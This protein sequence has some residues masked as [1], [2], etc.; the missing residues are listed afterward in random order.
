MDVAVSLS[1][2]YQTVVSLSP[3]GIYTK[4]EYGS[5]EQVDD[6]SGKFNLVAMSDDG[7][8]Q[9]ACNTLQKIFG[10]IKSGTADTDSPPTPEPTPEPTPQ[11]SPT[12]EPTPQPTPQPTVGA[13]SKSTAPPA[14]DPWLSRTTQTVMGV[15]LGG[16]AAG[17]TIYIASGSDN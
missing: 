17:G 9:V 13:A 8:D 2:K 3:G 16:V 14:D 6:V 5:W 4:F 11:P 1:G 15:F 7:L 12:P 10:V